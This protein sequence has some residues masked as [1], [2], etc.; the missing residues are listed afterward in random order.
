MPVFADQQ[1]HLSTVYGHKMQSKKQPGV[2]DERDQWV[3]QELGN[4]MVTARFDDDD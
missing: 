2:I 1:G 4:S 3:E